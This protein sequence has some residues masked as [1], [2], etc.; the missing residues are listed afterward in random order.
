MFEKVVCMYFVMI[1]RGV[2][3]IFFLRL[4]AIL[5]ISWMLGIKDVIIIAIKL[6]YISGLWQI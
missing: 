4:F 3:D 1:W 5:D 6:V 2:L